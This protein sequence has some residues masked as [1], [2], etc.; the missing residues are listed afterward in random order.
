MTAYDE[1][2]PDALALMAEH[3]ELDI[4][5]ICAEA[6]E[7]V[8]ALR[9]ELAIQ[10]GIS[11][12]LRVESEAR[13]RKLA[14]FHEGE[15][16]YADER[17]I[18]TPGQWIWRWNRAEPAERLDRA[19]RTQ[20]IWERLSRVEALALDWYD[21]PPL[22]PGQALADLRN[23]LSDDPQPVYC[24]AVQAGDY[25]IRVTGTRIP[26]ADQCAAI[27]A[28]LNATKDAPAVEP[29]LVGYRTRD[30]A[31]DEHPMALLEFLNQAADDQGPTP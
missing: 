7:E 30:G 12:D 8:A 16:P 15:E 9:T 4:V 24:Q 31:T 13:G 18:P 1:L 3:S 28:L 14:S 29:P 2:T 11:A 23:A 6:R 27:A 10:K 25:V 5:Q 19:T 17:L 21:A 20:A 26:T 22:L